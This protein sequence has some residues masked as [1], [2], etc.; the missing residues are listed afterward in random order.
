MALLKTAGIRNSTCLK[1]AEILILQLV[2]YVYEN[3]VAQATHI[4]H[5][6]NF[7]RSFPVVLVIDILY[8]PRTYEK[9]VRP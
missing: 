5:L 7:A 3:A 9:I 4:V 6:M 1:T 8:T 2:I